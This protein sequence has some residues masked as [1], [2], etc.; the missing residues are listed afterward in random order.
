[1]AARTLKFASPSISCVGK[2]VEVT[3]DDAV[4][5]LL[6]EAEGTGRAT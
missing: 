3:V 6:A 4:A 2:R 1:M 5:G